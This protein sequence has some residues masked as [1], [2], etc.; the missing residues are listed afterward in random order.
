MSRRVP[1]YRKHHTGQARVVI[2]GKTY[3][4]GKYNTPESRQLYKTLL[5]DHL[6]DTGRF[7]PAPA[8]ET[9]PPASATTVNDLVLAY[10]GHCAVYYGKTK[11]YEKVKLATRPLRKLH[12]RTPTTAFDAPAL[13]AVQTAMVESDLART[14]INE[15]IRVLKRMFRWGVRKKLVPSPVYGEI[16]TVEGLK[17]GRT[18]ARETAPVMPAPADHIEAVLARVNRHVAA[19]IRLQLLTGAVGRGLHHAA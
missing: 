15:R 16:L 10:F 7:A 17:R 13:E 6:T 8:P 3:Y 11:E 2:R 5:R 14:T 1:R 9:P 12:G 19:M 4:L 18:P